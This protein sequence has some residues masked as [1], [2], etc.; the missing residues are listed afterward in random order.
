MQTQGNRLSWLLCGLSS[1]A[2]GASS[3]APGAAEPTRTAAPVATPTQ[4]EPSPQQA[5]QALLLEDWEDGDSR[6]APSN[7]PSGLWS[8][9]KDLSG[10][11][12]TPEA[13]FV[14]ARGG[15][16]GSQY[17]GRIQGKLAAMQMVWAGLEEKL[18]DSGAAYDLSR[19][20]GVCFQAKGSGRAR[21][22]V[23]DVN[24]DPAGG[25]CQR[26]YNS[27][28]ADFTLSN[29][30]HQYCFELDALTQSCCWGEPHPAVT[31]EKAFS[32]TWSAHTPGVD[33]D[34]WIDDV[35]L[36]CD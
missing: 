27:F 34:L 28:G 14:P 26:C 8:S 20:R 10:S 30:W 33:Y 18:S 35:R 17:A 25:V 36:S 13:P 6:A 31:P 9:Y 16:H 24:T 19:W 21:F 1:C 3:A 4:S 22:T 7:G 2:C 11:T 15:A 29:D 23:P 32:L 5:C 12:L